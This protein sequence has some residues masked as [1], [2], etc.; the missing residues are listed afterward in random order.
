METS[1]EIGQRA[2][3]VDE[4]GAPTL[5]AEAIEKSFGATRA[6]GGVSVA[7]HAGE[8]H[9]LVGENGAGKSTLTRIL[10]GAL[11]AD[12]GRI[13]A[14]GRPVVMRTPLDGQAHGIRMVHQHDTLV[15]N[16]SVA[17]NILLGH[18]PRRPGGWLDWRAARARAAAV[19]A[20]L[21][22]AELDVRLPAYALSAARRQIVE[23]A[24][25][26]A[27]PPRVLIL[28]EPTAALAHAEVE[29]LFAFLRALRAQGVAIIYISHRLDEVLDLADRITVLR[30]G[31]VTGTLPVRGTDKTA[32][33][34]LMV[35]RAIEDLYPRR[36][37][38]AAAPALAVR[39]L[40]RAPSFEDVSFDVGAGEIVGLY[41]L[42][43]SGRSEMAR[44]LFGAD[45]AD[46]GHITWQ[47]RPFVPRRPR[48]ALAA[49][50]A[51]LTED[52]L[53]DGLVRGM[54]VRDNASLASFGA[55]TRWG[56]IRR[57]LQAARVGQQVRAL[58]VRPPGIERDVATLSGGN[59]Q[60]V[61]LAK[62][63][64]TEAR[65]L[66]LDEPT[67]GVDVGA[68]QDLYRTIGALAD[69]GVAVLL[70]SSDLPE[71]LG[72]CQRIL[73]M[74]A[75]RIAGCF[76]RAEASEEFLLACASGVSH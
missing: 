12:A 70:I 47:G 28:D 6:L 63:L 22:Q 64:L 30:D 24:K 59:Q 65:L 45:R 19:L 57:G 2:G 56:V 15:P 26:V 41:G 73:V 3:R 60:K 7:F 17:E 34:R 50:I 1:T 55:I 35:G 4:A 38:I 66:I 42:I 49:G 9:A 68:R 40:T 48:D 20:R 14:D 43:G 8:I 13:L 27:I 74:R 69:R 52:R 62:W 67:R 51:L 53:A 37:S 46:A 76:D 32:L 54:S 23:I 10:T 18:M 39:G 58:D 33:I 36:A 44:C 72:M 29:Q 61:V 25:A 71:V 21:G 5:A 31:R 11:R 75:G 16:L